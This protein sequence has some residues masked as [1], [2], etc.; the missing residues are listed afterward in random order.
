MDSSGCPTNSL[1]T[2]VIVDVANIGKVH[3]VSAAATQP[4][5]LCLRTCYHSQTSSLQMPKSNKIQKKRSCLKISTKD[6][7]L[8]ERWGNL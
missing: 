8:E 5:E 1:G 6:N 2:V 7:V 4:S 3:T